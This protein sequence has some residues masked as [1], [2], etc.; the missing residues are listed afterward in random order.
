MMAKQKL[1]K[2]A[3]V[4]SF[5]NCFFLS[6]EQSRDEGLPLKGK[7]NKDYFKNDNPIIL[8]LGC[9]KGEYTIG[10]A[11]RY[12]NKN[13]IGVDI[14]GNRIWTGAKTAIDDKMNNVAFIR[15]R[16]D[17]I[18]ACFK[19][20]EV[21]EIWITFPDP[22]PQKTRIRNRLT[23]MLFL[24][25]YKKILIDN[26]IVN[27]KTDS[28][29]F[30]NYTNEVVQENSFKVLDSTNDLYAETT[31]RDEELTTIKTYYEKKFSDMGFKICY[32]KFRV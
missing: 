19:D 26:G 8:E 32:L 13:F 6:F 3:E 27:L 4:S 15:T 5:D 24:N 20:N 30:Y 14:K 10:L 18:E 21:N 23:N 2:F 1:K 17:F 7:W 9:G 31:E 12:P 22:Q 25:R 29:P 16:I 28:E 11:K